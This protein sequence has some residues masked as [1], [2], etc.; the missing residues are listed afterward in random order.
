MMVTEL[1]SIWTYILDIS[2]ILWFN[3]FVLELN[4]NAL[5]LIQSASDWFLIYRNYL[6]IP[7][8]PKYSYSPC[9]WSSHKNWFHHIVIHFSIQYICAKCYLWSEAILLN[10]LSE[11]RSLKFMVVVKWFSIFEYPSLIIS[12]NHQNQGLV[13]NCVTV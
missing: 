1:L 4:T 10:W 12:R 6:R 7:K 8:W 2:N 3:S 13:F 11:N 9:Q 5:L